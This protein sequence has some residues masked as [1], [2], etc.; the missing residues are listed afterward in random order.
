MKK[1]IL[2][3]HHGK[4]IGGAA[5]SLLY[6]IQKIRPYYKI[7]VLFL[8]N[9]SVIELFKS[10]NIEYEILNKSHPLFIHSA[11][12]GGSL[13]NIKKLAKMM[14]G[15]VYFALFYAKKILKKENPDIIH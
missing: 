13:L 7:K 15:W 1:K 2:F 5:L 6:L 9:S 12:G 3:I 11:A 10:K 14:V 8:F 4:D